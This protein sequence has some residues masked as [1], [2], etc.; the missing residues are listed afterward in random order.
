[1]TSC[2]SVLMRIQHLHLWNES[3]LSESRKVQHVK[4]PVMCNTENTTTTANTAQSIRTVES[5]STALHLFQ[6]ATLSSVT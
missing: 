5:V 3:T 2:Q 4:T 1:M 6:C